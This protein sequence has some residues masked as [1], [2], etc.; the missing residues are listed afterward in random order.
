MA[1]M[2]V[3]VR[4][5]RQKGSGKSDFENWRQNGIILLV[6]HIPLPPDT[7][8]LLRERARAHGE[9]VSS[10]AAQLLRTALCTPS[11]DE[12]LAPFRKQIEASLITDEELDTLG[13]S[14]RDKV[15][16]EQQGKEAQGE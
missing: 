8:A 12:L 4:A 6:L 16:R 3:I 10:Y 2:L 7:E 5:G 14:L 15:W 11:V 13:E 1:V 9:D